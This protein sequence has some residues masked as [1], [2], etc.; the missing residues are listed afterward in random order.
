MIW[1]IRCGSVRVFNPLCHLPELSRNFPGRR[2][3][4]PP[5]PPPPLY[6]PPSACRATEASWNRGHRRAGAGGWPPALQAPGHRVRC[7]RGGDLMAG[8]R[9]RGSQPR[10]VYERQ[11]SRREPLGGAGHRRGSLPPASWRGSRLKARRGSRRAS[12]LEVQDKSW[13]R[14]PERWPR[15]PAMGLSSRG[16]DL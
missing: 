7:W 9:R 12:R 4:P 14:L 5:A 3:S 11:R 13:R 10:R 15:P 6:A 16:T 2:S 8:P 1:T